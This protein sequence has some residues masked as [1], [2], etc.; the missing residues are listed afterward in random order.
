[1]QVPLRILPDLRREL[2]RMHAHFAGT[3]AAICGK[4]PADSANDI[5]YLCTVHKFNH[6]M[7]KQFVLKMLRFRL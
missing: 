2:H 7:S 5:R 6:D 3:G 1:M 4:Y